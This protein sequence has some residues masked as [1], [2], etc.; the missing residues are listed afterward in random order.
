MEGVFLKLSPFNKEDMIL[1]LDL[2]G[3]GSWK[4]YCRVS[5]VKVE[6]GD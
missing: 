5:W 2:K 1:E 4:P 6:D 3:S